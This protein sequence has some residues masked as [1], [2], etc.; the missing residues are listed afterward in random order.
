ME[1]PKLFIPGPT[2]VDSELLTSLAEYPVGHRSALFSELYDEVVEGI[3]KVLFTSNR[4][5]LGTCSATGLMEAAVR[6]SVRK[7]CANFVCGAFSRR[8][9]EITAVSGIECDAVSV[10]LG[11]AVK[12]ELVRETLQT[13]KYDAVT[14]VHNETSTGVMNPIT[15]IAE[16]VRDFPDVALLVDMVSSMASIKVE[17]DTLGIDVALASVQKGWGLPPGFAVC[18]VTDIVMERSGQISNKGYYFDFLVMEKYAKKSQTPT[19]P[20]IPHMFG[21]K[22][23]LSRIFEEELENRFQR[24][25]DMA[26]EVRNWVKQK[27][28]LFAEPG[29]ESDTV[30]CAGNPNGIDLIEMASRLLDRGYLISGGYG[31]LKGKTFRIAHMGN[32]KMNDIRELLETMDNVLEEI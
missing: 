25:R 30:T 29:Y 10:E 23:Q 18:S 32:L 17:V 2:H 5:F 7:R 1:K 31:P 15:E 11:K 19:T 28:D 26:E 21:L 6:N 24:H 4:I 9:H 13:G 16:V 3:Q 27:F 14:I 20:S 12:P 8:W 22:A